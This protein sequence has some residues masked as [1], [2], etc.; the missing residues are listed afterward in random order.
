MKR[1]TN[2]AA[3]LGIT[4]LIDFGGGGGG[5]EGTIGSNAGTA[6]SSLPGVV[7]FPEVC[8]GFLEGLLS[9]LDLSLL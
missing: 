2:L 6:S 7:A 3:F 5:I 4:D 9:S 8:S 1:K